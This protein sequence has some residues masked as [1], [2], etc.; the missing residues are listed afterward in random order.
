MAVAAPRDAAATAKGMK[1]NSMRTFI[2]IM[3][4]GVVCAQ[5]PDRLM[6]ALSDR[7]M[8][9]QAMRL[10][11]DDRIAMYQSLVQAKPDDLHYHNLLAGSFIQKVRET[12]DFSYLDRASQIL[13]N[14]ISLDSQNYEALRLRSEVELERHNFKK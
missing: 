14:V 1:E 7:A 9:D 13:E 2:L 8:A 4:A 11:T 12:T 10:K 5:D 6:S 3:F